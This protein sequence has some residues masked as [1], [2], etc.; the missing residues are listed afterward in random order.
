MNHIRSWLALMVVLFTLGACS[1]TVTPSLPTTT[2]ASASINLDAETQ[3]RIQTAQRVVFLVPFSHWDTDW[4][5]N[6]D[7]YVA[8]S[9][10]NI[11]AAIQLAK[12]HPR[13]RYALE[14]VLFVQHFWDAH[15]EARADLVAAVQRRQITFAWAGITQPETSLVSPAIQIRNL[16]LGEDWIAQTF[17]RE[18]IPHT[19]WQSDAFGTSAIFPTF[20]AQA[21]IPYLYVGRGPG[22]C[23]PNDPSCKPLPQLFYWT[24]PAANARV[25]VA[26]LAYPNA[27]DATHRIDNAN[28]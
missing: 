5:E 27:W 11:L 6:Y 7:A 17:G 24:S 18:F 8:L 26:N 16:Q 10:R 15:P 23:D 9:D 21:S 22:R 28:D 14:Q 19:A 25:L 1:Q 13:F 2:P 12:Q 4:H 3:A 20:L